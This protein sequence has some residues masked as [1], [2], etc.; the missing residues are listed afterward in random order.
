MY[1]AKTR[2]GA[3]SDTFDRGRCLTPD[4]RRQATEIHVL[5]TG[6]EREP[7]AESNNRKTEQGPAVM[8]G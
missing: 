4:D 2:I 8:Q 1:T 3:G 7:D 5:G 6:A